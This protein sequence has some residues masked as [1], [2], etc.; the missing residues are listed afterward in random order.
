[1]T[2]TPASR[3]TE[4]EGCTVILFPLCWRKGTVRR[5]AEK[6]V[7]SKPPARERYWRGTL[8]ALEQQLERLGGEEE[9]N[10][11]ELRQFTAAVQAEVYRIQG[12]TP[13]PDGAA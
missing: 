7:T 9:G 1:M 2:K 12:H 4:I 6:M 13:E 11:R 5:V 3:K 8:D 10:D